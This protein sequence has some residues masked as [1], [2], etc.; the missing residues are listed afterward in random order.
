MTSPTD[1]QR[2]TRVRWTIVALLTGLSLTSYLLRMNISVASKFMMPELGLTQIQMGQVFSSFLIGYT[3]FQIPTGIWSDRRGPKVVLSLAALSWGTMTVLTGFVPGIVI[4]GA[5]AFAALLALRFLLGV[6]EAATYPVGARAVASWSP[7]SER[8]LAQAIVLGGISVGSAVTPPVIALLMVKVGWRESFYMV[9]TVAFV[10]AALWAW[11]AAD[12][13]ER[14]PGTNP[15]ERRLIAGAP[16]ERAS[17]HAGPGTWLRVFRNRDVALVSLSYFFDGY[18]FYI[19]IFWTFTYLVEQRGF[20]ILS[21]GAYSSL[22]FICA[23]I[24]TPIGGWTS[25]RLL[26][27]LG[28]RWARRSPA[29]AGMVLA[30]LFIIL[31]ALV[32]N[33][34]LAIAGL[35]FSIG[36]DQFAEPTFWAAT[37]DISGPLAGTACGILNMMG[38]LGGV[39]STSFVPVLVKYFGWGVALGSGA[40]FA[41]VSALLWLFVRADCPMHEAAIPVAF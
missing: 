33:P 10:I 30:G 41:F 12:G 8:A 1:P 5:G 37:M 24:L 9:S 39:V 14:H 19:V 36:F 38:N 4:G 35:G 23:G 29:I 13:P 3:V 22:P 21:G 32:R 26:R 31:A 25:D 40:A 16:G 15:A 7:V 11:Y 18:I 20:S 6:G 2:P 17:D 34:Y 27:P 28:R